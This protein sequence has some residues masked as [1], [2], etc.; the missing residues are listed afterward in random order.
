MFDYK[1]EPSL[2]NELCRKLPSNASFV[3]EVETWNSLGEVET[4]D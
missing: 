2:H 4:G 3:Q 1:V